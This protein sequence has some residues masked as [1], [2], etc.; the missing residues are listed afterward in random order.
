MTTYPCPHCG[1]HAEGHAHV[2]DGQA[3]K[4]EARAGDAGVCIQCAQLL[5]VQEVSPGVLGHVKMSRD[6]YRAL[7]GTP[8]I[9]Q[10]QRLSCAALIAIHGKNFV[11]V[12]LRK[13]PDGSVRVCPILVVANAAPPEPAAPPA[14]APRRTRLADPSNN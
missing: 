8:A 1:F 11:G 4:S 14:P 13:D 12:E 7:R 6:F 2:I 3:V 5:V 10:M 9:E